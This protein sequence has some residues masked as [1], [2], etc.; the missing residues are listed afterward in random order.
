M[1]KDVTGAEVNLLQICK[2][3]TSLSLFKSGLYVVVWFGTNFKHQI[4]HVNLLKEA[5][6]STETF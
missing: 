6:F 3:N 1:V 2:L 4:H 5:L